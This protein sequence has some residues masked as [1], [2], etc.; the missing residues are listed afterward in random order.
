MEFRITVGI[1]QSRFAASRLATHRFRFDHFA[2]LCT[3]GNRE[4]VT[5]FTARA[6]GVIHPGELDGDVLVVAEHP[7]GAGRRLEVSMSTEVTEQDRA[8][9]MNTY[10]LVNENQATI[11]GGVRTWHWDGEQIFIFLS[12]EAARVLGAPDGYVI[13]I[14]D[15]DNAALAQAWLQRILGGW[16]SY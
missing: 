3:D 10:S 15:S 14:P 11:Y 16:F 7:D 1:E 6:V 9:G 8:L 5:E 13:P 4:H 12:E 2:T